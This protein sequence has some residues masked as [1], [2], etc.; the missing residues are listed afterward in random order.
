M[1]NN[2]I[3]SPFRKMEI[4]N[5]S[6]NQISNFSN[7]VDS[8]F[9]LLQE[10]DFNQLNDQNLVHQSMYIL[11]NPQNSIT[12]VKTVMKYVMISFRD[13]NNQL[14]HQMK[15]IP[16]DTIDFEL[17]PKF[18]SYENMVT[19]KMEYSIYTNWKDQNNQLLPTIVPSENKTFVPSVFSITT[20]RFG[21]IYVVSSFPSGQTEDPIVGSF[22]VN[23]PINLYTKNTTYMDILFKPLIQRTT[24]GSQIEHK[25]SFK[26]E[27][28][29]YKP[30]QTESFELYLKMYSDTTCTTEVFEAY[31]RILVTHKSG[32]PIGD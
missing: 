27:P 5:E 11:S 6:S 4:K 25:I 28:L 7:N 32:Q 12:S 22:K 29:L 23:S 9:K 2:N 17:L 21:G 8:P 30:V 3:K 15:S 14:I 24:I 26:I 18:S 1:N 19:K 31:V 20:S 13:P 16:G 10:T